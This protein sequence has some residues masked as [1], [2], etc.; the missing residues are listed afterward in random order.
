MTLAIGMSLLV[1]GNGAVVGHV[2]RAFVYS[3]AAVTHGRLGL[4]CEVNFFLYRTE[5]LG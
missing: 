5:G 2:H 1:L 4:V 3:N